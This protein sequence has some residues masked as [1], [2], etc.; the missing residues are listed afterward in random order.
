MRLAQVDT[1]GPLKPNDSE[2]DVV[3][4]F[5]NEDDRKEFEDY[6]S[7]DEDSYEYVVLDEEGGDF[8]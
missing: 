6:Y 2:S 3:V 1:Y 7:V 4:L 5:H 8:N